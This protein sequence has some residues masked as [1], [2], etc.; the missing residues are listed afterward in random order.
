MAVEQR[1]NQQH[2]EVKQQNR[3]VRHRHV[4]AGNPLHARLL[5]GERVGAGVHFIKALCAAAELDG[6][7]KAA[8]AVQHKA[9]KRAGFRAE[10]Q[11]VIAGKTRGDKGHD[12]A[13]RN[14]RQQ[15]EASQQRMV[16]ADEAAE[17]HREQ[18]RDGCG[19]DGVRIKDFQKLDIGGDDRDQVA[20][21]AP[22]ELSG[23]E[24]AQRAKDVIANQRQEL[25][26][27]KVVAGLLRIAEAAAHQREHQ[28]ADK[29]RRERNGSSEPQQVEHSVAAEDRDE[30]RAEMP[31]QTHQD[32]QSH[33]AG[34]R[35]DQADQP[36]HDGKAAAFLLR[37]HAFAPPFS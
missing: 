21:V 1:G 24:A 14:I 25:E 15:R 4:A 32:R 29:D 33:I 17:N 11:P 12:H 16:A 7:R 34:Q 19:G 5:F 26:G 27:D 20:L 6:F 23:A 31:H 13:H 8:Q 2:D 10:P 28:H 3:R 37:V 18:Q 9:G 30:A 22:F 35:L 36:E